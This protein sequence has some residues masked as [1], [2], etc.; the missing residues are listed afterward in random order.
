MY[1]VQYHTYIKYIRLGY[2]LIYV[3]AHLEDPVISK[4]NRVFFL[5]LNVMYGIFT[6]RYI[7]V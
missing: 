1:N 7:A 3:T 6:T 2:C 5:S 4:V